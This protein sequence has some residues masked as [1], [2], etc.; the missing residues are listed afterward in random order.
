MSAD[1]F[2]AFVLGASSNHP[3]PLEAELLLSS[4]GPLPPSAP[5]SSATARR[6]SLALGS[7]QYRPVEAPTAQSSV[8][9]ELEVP[10]KALRS[11]LDSK[12]SQSRAP[13][14]PVIRGFAAPNP[15]ATLQGVDDEEGSRRIEADVGQQQNTDTDS[16]AFGISPE[17]WTS[18]RAQYGASFPSSELSIVLSET[19]C[20]FRASGAFTTLLCLRLDPRHAGMISFKDFQVTH[21]AAR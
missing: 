8:G 14:R 4:D 18:V 19:G 1:E 12:L 15:D 11:P 16:L 5:R 17:A 21:H 20:G 3:D 2:S 7:N 13:S 9:E 6:P 10:A